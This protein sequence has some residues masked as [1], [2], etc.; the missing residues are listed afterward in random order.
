MAII[1]GISHLKSKPNT[2]PSAVVMHDICTNLIWYGGESAEEK[3]EVKKEVSHIWK[4]YYTPIFAALHLAALLD[5][6]SQF[7]ADSYHKIRFQ[8]RKVYQVSQNQRYLY[9]STMQTSWSSYLSTMSRDISDCQCSRIPGKVVN[10]TTGVDIQRDCNCS[11]RLY[12]PQ[13]WD[14]QNCTSS[15]PSITTSHPA[16]PWLITI[17]HSLIKNFNHCQ[18]RHCNTCAKTPKPTL[19]KK[20]KTGTVTQTL[21]CC[22]QLKI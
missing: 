21:R 14:C 5:I 15:Y 1:T 17:F 3:W 16:A 11:A 18:P 19:Q 2:S 12:N 10:E 22:S 4:S 13:G 8:C 9:N 6:P 7:T 20:T